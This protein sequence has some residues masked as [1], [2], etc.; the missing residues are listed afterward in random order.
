MCLMI[1]QCLGYLAFYF[2]L[3]M[4]GWLSAAP[5]VETL[6]SRIYAVHATR[7]LPSQG[8]LTTGL[9]NTLDPLFPDFR[10]T[11]HFSLGE[12]V[13][14]VEGVISW[15][16][17]PFALVTPLKTLIP[18]LINVNCYDTFILG[19]FQ[20]QETSILVVPE[21]YREQLSDAAWYQCHFYNPLDTTLRL[22]VD[23]VIAE[24]GGWA[25]RMNDEDR[26][27]ELNEAY[28]EGQNINTLSF[29]FPLKLAYPYLSIGT[30]FDSLDGEAYLFGSLEVELWQLATYFFAVAPSHTYAT[31][32][33]L[34]F[35]RDTIADHKYELS[36][37]VSSLPFTATAEGPFYQKITLVDT[38][39]NIIQAELYLRQMY[40]KSL[41]GSRHDVWENI[42]LRRLSLEGICK[43]L[44]EIWMDLANYNDTQ[45]HPSWQFE[46]PSFQHRRF[47]RFSPL[48]ALV[49]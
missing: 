7:M 41:V 27:D 49:G 15:E 34:I 3:L 1:H 48:E 47:H 4:M 12:M 24:Q 22:A 11:L 5:D 42:Y 10:C 40:K 46:P 16:D 44:D 32:K 9:G 26:E 38:W 35:A 6:T 28:F 25:I 14:P 43:Y 39:I 18:Q 33:S 8:I 21:S 37:Y 29:F 13:R 20:L 23:Q 31:I 17:C 36:N 19:D 2:S 45:N 30:R